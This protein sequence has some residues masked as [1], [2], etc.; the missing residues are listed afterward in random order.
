M[1]SEGPDP[2]WGVGP[3]LFLRVFLHPDV[4]ASITRPMREVEVMRN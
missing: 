3:S 4:A 1:C 2:V